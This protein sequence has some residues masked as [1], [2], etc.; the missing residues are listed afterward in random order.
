MIWKKYMECLVTMPTRLTDTAE[1]LLDVILTNKPHYFKASGVYNPE[2]SDHALVYGMLT[3]KV[4]HYQ[5]KVVTFRD[6]KKLDEGSIRENLW[7]APWYASEIFD[8]Q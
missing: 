6:F 5:S 7:T 4:K 3:E 2:V 8:S 1:S